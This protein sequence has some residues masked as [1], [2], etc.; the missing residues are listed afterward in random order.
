MNSSD[1]QGGKTPKG[2][3]HSHRNIDPSTLRTLDVHQHDYDRCHHHSVRM[4]VLPVLYDRT[5]SSG[6]DLTA[7]LLAGFGKLTGPRHG[8]DIEPY[9][10]CS[11]PSTSHRVFEHHVPPPRSLA[12]Q[13]ANR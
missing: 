11:T 8:A 4:D 5:P 10:T 1:Q 6:A 9:S 3:S 7:C 13:T 2:A 12:T